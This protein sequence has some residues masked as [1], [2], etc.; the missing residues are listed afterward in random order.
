[1]VLRKGLSSVSFEIGK[2]SFLLCDVYI[3]VC[4]ESSSCLSD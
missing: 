2:T 3:T 4:K 1:M